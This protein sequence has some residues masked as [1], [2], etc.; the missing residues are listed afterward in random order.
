MLLI[1]LLLASELQVELHTGGNK[2][3]Q[4]AINHGGRGNIVWLPKL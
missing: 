1:L 4:S 2:E 3:K